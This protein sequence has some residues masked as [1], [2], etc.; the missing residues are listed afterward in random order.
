MNPHTFYYSKT[1]F[2]C[3]FV[4]AVI[5]VLFAPVAIDAKSLADYRKS[6]RIV[7]DSVDE[8]S[9]HVAGSENKTSEKN[10]EYERELVALIRTNLPATEKIEWQGTSVET[11]NQWLS[12]KLD[13]F[14]REENP[15]K[16][17]EILATVGERLSSL[18]EKIV[19]LENSSVSDHTKDEDK[20]KL[21]EILSREDY[22]K[23]EQNEESLLQ[24][25]WRQ[26]M[27]WL[28][29]VFPSPNLSDAQPT[30]FQSF[31]LI[32]QILV[33]ALVAGVIGFTVYK[34]APLFINKYR[35][36]EKSEKKDRVILGEKIAANESAENLFV[37]AEKL[38][39]EGNLRAAIRKGY[40]AVLCD[41]SDK[42]I[43]GLAHYKT[44]R[45]Y[46]R[47][48]RKH[49]VIYENMNGLTDSFERHWYGF[50]SADDRDWN[51]FRQE[52][53]KVVS[54]HK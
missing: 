16:R 11:G 38:A 53:K 34:F 52:Y 4:L 54:E 26:L 25:W 41:L 31:S 44:N 5:L 35:T 47:D 15:V 3:P 24:R 45:D 32:L 9:I 40:I 13:V 6:V 27:E 50:Q 42:K 49:R 20:R 28:E 18:Q 23:P 48:V 46:L 8:L 12:D 33:Y 2:L 17:A 43:I 19:E 30:G 10:V 7:R 36:R 22:R 51:E 37:E 29:S 1:R 39:R 14:Q 21:A